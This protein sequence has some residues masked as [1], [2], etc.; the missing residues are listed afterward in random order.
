MGIIGDFGYL[1]QRHNGRRMTREMGL[2]PRGV[3][4]LMIHCAI[5]IEIYDS[6]HTATPP[7]VLNL[8]IELCVVL[9]LN[10]ERRI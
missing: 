10:S 7:M 2:G 9:Q 4:H 3:Y 5:E 8:T 1:E 6:Y